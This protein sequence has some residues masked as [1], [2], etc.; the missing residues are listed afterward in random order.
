MKRLIVDFKSPGATVETVHMESPMSYSS[1]T[2]SSD[3]KIL[4]ASY[5]AYLGKFDKKFV[6]LLARW[7]DIPARFH[8]FWR[9]EDVVFHRVQGSIP[10]LF[11]GLLASLLRFSFSD[12]HPGIQLGTMEKLIADSLVADRISDEL[13]ALVDLKVLGSHHAL[14]AEGADLSLAGIR[15]GQQLAVV[16]D[17]VLAGIAPD[18]QLAPAI[19]NDSREFRWARAHKVAEAPVIP[20]FTSTTPK[21]LSP[22]FTFCCCSVLSD[23]PSTGWEWGAKQAACHL[24]KFY[25]ATM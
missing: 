23:T 14:V 1:Q 3:K 6:E 25:Q 8:Q 7:A 12:R 2:L 13:S 11:L 21:T 16:G 15:H 17:T 9:R 5:D 22:I 18:A 4:C 10:D 24:E 19:I 20:P